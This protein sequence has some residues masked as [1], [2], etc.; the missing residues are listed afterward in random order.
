M[1]YTVEESMIYKLHAFLFLF[2]SVPFLSLC[3]EEITGQSPTQNTVDTT[4]IP[5]NDPDWQNKMVVDDEVYIR[6]MLEGLDDKENSFEY[7]KSQLPEWHVQASLQSMPQLLKGIF[8]YL[9]SYDSNN[10]VPSYH[11]FILVGKPGVGKTTLARSIAQSLGYEVVFIHASELLGKYRNHTAINLRELFDQVKKDLA[12]KVVIIDELHKLFENHTYKRTDDAASATAFWNQ[13]DELEKQYPNI[14]VIGTA[15]SVDKMPPEI[16]SRFH[17]KIITMP[18]PDKAQCQK[19]LQEILAHDDSIKIESHVIAAVESRLKQFSLRDVQLLVD[20]AKMFRYA[21]LPFG[22]D[23]RQF[24][25][26]KKH[27]ELAIK[28]LAFENKEAWYKRMK[29]L[30]KKIATGIHTG[31]ELG[32]I[33]GGVVSVYQIFTRDSNVSVSHNS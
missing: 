27:F 19:V 29:P 22:A 15:N 5:L 4:T 3:Q 32:L 7:E 33:V 18:L 23:G 2:L 26:D 20:T 11:R 8:H 31:A 14:V 30:L 1:F 28:Q 10:P 21:Q 6:H 16:K 17:G 25:L 9:K 13:L 12:N 24:I